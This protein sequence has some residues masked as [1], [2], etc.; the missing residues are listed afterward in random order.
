MLESI[1]AGTLRSKIAEGVGDAGRSTNDVAAFLA[2]NHVDVA[3]RFEL[4]AG[5]LRGEL[6]LVTG[7]KE[8]WKLVLNEHLKLDPLTTDQA[9][10]SRLA[11]WLHLQD[12][13]KPGFTI[14]PSLEDH[15][16]AAVLMLLLDAPDFSRE[17]ATILREPPSNQQK[18]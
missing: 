15:A 4:V 5:T 16:R 7:A 6:K 10:R 1:E 11:S 14:E 9:R 13:T 2:N 8:L 12:N 17:L 3:S 18:A